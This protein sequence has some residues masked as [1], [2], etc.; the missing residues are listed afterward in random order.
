M[1]KKIASVRDVLLKKDLDAILIGKPENRRYISSFTGTTG[2]VIITKDEAIFITDFR[3]M[4]QAQKECKLFKIIETSRYEPLTNILN[5]LNIGRLGVEEEFFTYG[6][7]LDLQEKLKNLS[8]VALEGALTKI[9]SIKSKEEIEY[10]TTAASIADK[11]FAYILDFLK[12]GAIEEDIALEL[13]FFMRKQGASGVSFN[14]IVAS[15][16][17]SSLPHG[18]ASN[19]IIEAGDFVTLDFGC[20]YEGYCSD[21]TRTMVVG[22]ASTK[23]KEIYSIVLQAQKTALDAVKPGITGKDLDSIARSIIEEAGYG[24]NFGHGLGHGV[25]LEVHELP[26]VNIIGDIPMEP[27]MVITIEPGIY[28]PGFGGVRIEDLVVVTENGYKVLSK[29][30]KE[31]IEIKI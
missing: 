19:K 12:P 23:Q 3:Y 6:H 22:E 7:A 4:Q 14:F 26:H 25:G 2:F 8:L 30:S 21:M 15:G 10:I 5:E 20:I 31:L 11:A 29:T 18:T 9:R 24:D 17:R 13:E 16:E 27:G 28:I 1:H